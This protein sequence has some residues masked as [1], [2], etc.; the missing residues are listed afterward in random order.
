[1][2]SS[3]LKK[4]KIPAYFSSQQLH[5]GLDI[6][7]S[8]I[9]L[10]ALEK[11]GKEKI[12]HKALYVELSPGIEI[13]AALKNLFNS[14]GIPERLVNV[15][16]SGQSVIMRYVVVPQMT[17]L[18]LKS[19]MQ[20]EAG[21][22]LPFPLDEV[23]LDCAILKEKIDTNKMLVVLAAIK[24]TALDER[25]TLID[26]AG[27]SLKIIDVD[28]FCLANLFAHGGPSLHDT[29]DTAK[30]RTIAL[31]NIGAR[32]TNM[33][34]MED[35]CLR[36]SRDIAFG[37]QEQALPGLASEINSSFDYFENQNGRPIEKIYL[38]GGASL[39]ADI[40]GS[41]SRFLNV[42][43]SPFEVFSGLKVDPLVNQEELKPKSGL[44]AIALGL[45]LR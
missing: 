24:K 12:L 26:K 2:N 33:A 22:H 8:A 9:K 20:F 6:G 27:L 28:C 38:S 10:V 40:A 30:A 45:A 29:L 18:E 39:Q 14:E 3:I 4:F 23:I 11:K 31:L 16:V 41:L 42:P 43:A 35:N 17:S 15:S 32:Y 5:I 7:A 37:G 34:I 44:F 1:M 25:I 36:F 21:Q 19:T 13:S